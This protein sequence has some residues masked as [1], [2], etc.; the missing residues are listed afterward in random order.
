MDAYLNVTAFRAYNQWEPGVGQQ[1]GIL[2][3][4]QRLRG[5]QV[6]NRKIAFSG[7]GTR[8]RFDS[9]EPS[10]VLCGPDWQIKDEHNPAQR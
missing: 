6:T 9:H 4:E 3:R 10:C 7:A 2:L 1:T 5:P 8:F